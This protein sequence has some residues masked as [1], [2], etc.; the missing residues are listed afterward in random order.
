MYYNDVNSEPTTYYSYVIDMS[1]TSLPLA[2]ASAGTGASA[3]A[4]AGQQT[5][6]TTRSSRMLENLGTILFSQL[7]Q[8]DAWGDLTNVVV[9]PTA[10]QIQNA[11]QTVVYMSDSQI[12]SQCPITL[13][14]FQPND[15]VLQ[16]RHCGHIFRPA[17]LRNWFRRNVRCPVCRYDIRAFG[18][19]A[20]RPDMTTE[21]GSGSETDE[22]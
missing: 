10:Q 21:T 17:A 15:H 3:G 12:N 14:E 4:G 6:R 1:Y 20:S 11:T 13:E 16:I 8:P 2:G 18:S 5:N 9:A 22:W 19:S 7:L